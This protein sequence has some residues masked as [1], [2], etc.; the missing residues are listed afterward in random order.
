ML[1][2][3]GAYTVKDVDVYRGQTALEKWADD[4]NAQKHLTMDVKL[5]KNIHT[6]ICSMPRRVMVQKSVIS[7]DC[8]PHGSV[9]RPM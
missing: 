7:D 3:L 4:P 5:K 8:L 2:N 6:A 9:L 1:E